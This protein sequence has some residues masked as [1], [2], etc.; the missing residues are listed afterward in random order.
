[1]YSTTRIQVHSLDQTSSEEDNDDDDDLDDLDNNDNNN[2]GH[3][4]QTNGHAKKMATTT[5]TTRKVDQSS[6]HTLYQWCIEM[7]APHCT[8]LLAS[9]LSS[10][11][12]TSSH[13]QNDTNDVS[14][15]ANKDASSAQTANSPSIVLDR[16]KQSDES[17]TI[18]S[19]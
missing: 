6:G 4:H 13:D 5:A 3:Y 10:S 11:L 8:A 17:L 19:N 7:K 12:S 18:L 14:M 9:S 2:S 16:P 15:T 1:L